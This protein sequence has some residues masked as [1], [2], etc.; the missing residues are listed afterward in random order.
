MTDVAGRMVTRCKVEI[1]NA[2]MPLRRGRPFGAR[3]FDP[4]HLAPG[5]FFAQGTS[6][7]EGSTAMDEQYGI[8][9]LDTFKDLHWAFEAK[10]ECKPSAKAL[11]AADKRI[12]NAKEALREHVDS[13]EQLLNFLT[14]IQRRVDASRCT[15]RLIRWIQ[16]TVDHN[17][18]AADYIITLAGEIEVDPR[19]FTYDEFVEELQQGLTSEMPDEDDP[20]EW[21]R[22]LSK[23]V[24]A[25]ALG[26]SSS[27]KLTA[28]AKAGIYPLRQ[29]GNRETWQINL[30]GIPAERRTKLL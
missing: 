25:T 17:L 5:F 4:P 21:S 24:I 29:A 16:D 28:L 27:D 12:A 20:E 9:L 1:E 14:S 13:P 2:I 3:R 18:M 6:T 23:I 26:L 19:Q 11:Q 8:V 7:G 15:T 22:P 10:R 30:K